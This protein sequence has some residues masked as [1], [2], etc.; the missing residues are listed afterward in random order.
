M[1]LRD[2]HWLNM[3]SAV[4]RFMLAVVTFIMCEARGAEML[5]KICDDC[6]RHVLFF[7]M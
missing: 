6:V 1:M 5:H 7:C 3:L 4:G 2:I